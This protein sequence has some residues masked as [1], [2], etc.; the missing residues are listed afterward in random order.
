MNTYE[1]SL[2]VFPIEL[3][4]VLSFQGSTSTSSIVYSMCI[5][6]VQVKI[7][8]QHTCTVHVCLYVHIHVHVHVHVPSGC[9]LLPAWFPWY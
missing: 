2:I 3:K 9:S 8:M 4:E 6:F 5:S 7:H 1:A